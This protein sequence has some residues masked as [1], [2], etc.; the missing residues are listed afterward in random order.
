MD[1][2]GDGK[3]N[4]DITEN[5][6]PFFGFEGRKIGINKTNTYKK[7]VKKLNR[8]FFETEVIK[9][10]GKKKEYC[11]RCGSEITMEKPVGNW[12]NGENLD[13]I[14][15]PCFCSFDNQG[16]ICYGE[17]NKGY[18]SEADK[19]VYQITDIT[20]QVDGSFTKGQM[21]SVIYTADTIKDLIKYHN[22]HIKHGKI[23]IF[24]EEK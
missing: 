19:D 15:F 23:I 17:I 18:I 4:I 11:P 7:E 22:V 3:H 10:K 20:R 12:V 5:A 16:K 24:E 8:P 1:Y 21:Y 6:K 13:K 9:A 2:T 14:K